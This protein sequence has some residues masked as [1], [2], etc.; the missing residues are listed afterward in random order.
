LV[1][2]KVYDLLGNEAATLVNEY[3]P[4]GNY[5]IVFNADGLSSGIYFYKLQEGSFNQIKKI[6]MLK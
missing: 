2:Q 3:K 1:T 4:A 6:T 5:E